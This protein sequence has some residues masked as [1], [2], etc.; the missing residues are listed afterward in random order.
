MKFW[1]DVVPKWPSNLV[2]ISE[3]KR[4]FEERVFV[5]EVDLAHSQVVWS[6]PETMDQLELFGDRCDSIGKVFGCGHCFGWIFV[7]LVGKLFFVF[8]SII[9]RKDTNAR[10][11]KRLKNECERELQTPNDR[12]CTD[13][14]LQHLWFS[15][16]FYC[17]YTTCDDRDFQTIL[18]CIMEEQPRRSQLL[19]Y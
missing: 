12:M 15:R 19:E 3:F 14:N 9:R 7:V 18:S 16:G 5:E 6:F 4:S 8:L 2:D 17:R 13:K 1:P 11:K 10:G